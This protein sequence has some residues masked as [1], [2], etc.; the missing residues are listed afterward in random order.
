MYTTHVGGLLFKR[1]LEA[2]LD[3]RKNQLLQSPLPFPGD[4]GGADTLANYVSGAP[5][6]A[7]EII[8]MG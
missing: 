8:P 7:H 6:S 2:A 3:Q 4:Y 1:A 5:I